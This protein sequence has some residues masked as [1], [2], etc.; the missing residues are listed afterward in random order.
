MPY[1]IERSKLNDE[2]RRIISRLDRRCFPGDKREPFDDR[3]WW[4]VWHVRGKRRTPV[5]YAGYKESTLAGHVFFCR[6][7]ILAPHRRQGL[8]RRLIKART[9]YARRMG[10][11]GV[12]TYALK[13]NTV[14]ANSLATCG[15]KLYTPK[16]E[17]AG[18]AFYMIKEF[19]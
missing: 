10:Y 15:F 11:L 17:Y 19:A 14:S 5:G 8:H 16:I 9:Q 18:P 7:G 3:T 13:H 6:A 12:V 4:I 2:H 1:V